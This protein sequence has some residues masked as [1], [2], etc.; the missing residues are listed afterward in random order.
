MLGCE[1]CIDIG[2]G[3]T[4]ISIVQYGDHLEGDGVNLEAELLFRDSSS[5]AGDTLTKE[6]ID[7]VLLPWLGSRFAADPGQ[8]SAF[9]N[10]FKR[11]DLL[12]GPKARWSRIVKLVLLPIVRQWLKDLPRGSFECP[13]TGAPWSPDRILGAEGRLV[14]PGALAEFNQFCR[15]SGL[16]EE[17]N[18]IDLLGE[19]DPIMCE[20]AN[21]AQCI[22]RVFKPL[23]FSLAKYV[24]AFDVDVVTLSGKPSELPQVKALLERVLPIL[25]QRIVQAKDFPAGDWYPMSSDTRIHDA[26]SVTAV[27]AALYQA[28]YNGRIPRWSIKRLGSGKIGD[29]Y[30]G[31]MPAKVQP[32]R[33]GRLYLSPG[34]SEATHP[35]LIGTCIGR[36]L[37]PSA[38]KPEQVYRLRWKDR[39]KWVGVPQNATLH[40]TL[41]R[42]LGAVADETESLKITAVEGNA[43]GKPVSLDDVELQL[44]TLDGD[45][46]WMDNGRFEVVWP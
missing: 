17:L 35:I 15:E 20:P 25:P 21:V 10:I 18:G 34:E 27:G 24:T 2:G 11:T 19:S 44:C 1:S 29:N 39:D 13:L 37:L 23:I 43:G 40:V 36:K 38:A 7:C 28:I 4:D 9:E 45:E 42:V 32:D 16:K 12:P 3:T 41:S 6:I 46:F 5:V 30:W 8:T 33:F 26:K 31:S 14:D 22:D